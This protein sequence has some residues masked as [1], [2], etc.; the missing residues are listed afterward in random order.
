MNDIPKTC[1]SHTDLKSRFIDN[2]NDTGNAI[3]FKLKEY[4]DH[5]YKSLASFGINAFVPGGSL[6][7]GRVYFQF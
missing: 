2:V 5:L 4:S 7:I 6:K 1:A 3:I